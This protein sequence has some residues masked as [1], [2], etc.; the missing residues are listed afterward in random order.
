[1]LG[2]YQKKNIDHNLIH[3]FIQ[4]TDMWIYQIAFFLKT[5]F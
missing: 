5:K 2:L 4:Q 3:S 1:M